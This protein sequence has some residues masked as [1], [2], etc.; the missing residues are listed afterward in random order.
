MYRKFLGFTHD[1]IMGLLSNSNYFVR[2]DNKLPCKL[3]WEGNEDGFL[4]S[5][6]SSF[7]RHYKKLNKEWPVHLDSYFSIVCESERESWRYAKE[8]PDSKYLF[9][10]EKTYR[11]LHYHPF[12][13]YSESAGV[14]KRLR[15]LGFETFPE[16]FDESYD[17]IENKELRWKKVT[18]ELQKVLSMDK[19]KLHEIHLKLKP[20]ILHNHYRARDFEFSDE[21]YEELTK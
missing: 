19:R 13:V 4:K 21:L 1:K 18:Q 16:L 8:I 9:L 12:I 3:V 6:E 2:V 10:T 11:C 15:E 20:K 7:Y 17:E 14:L 5:W